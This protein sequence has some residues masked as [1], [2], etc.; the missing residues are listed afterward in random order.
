MRLQSR[1]VAPAILLVLLTLGLVVPRAEAQRGL[2]VNGYVEPAYGVRSADEGPITDRNVMQETRLMIEKKFYGDGGEALDL[3]VLATTNDATNQS[4]V[5]L[6][7]GSVFLPISRSIEMKIGRQVLSWGPSQFEFINDHFA[8]D[9][10]SFFV[11]RNLEFLKAPNDAVKFSYYGDWAN[12]DLVASPAFEPDRLPQGQ[13]IPLYHP[14]QRQ[15]V[16]ASNAPTVQTPDDSP[17]E[18]EYHL[19]LNQ[20]FGRWETALYGYRGFVGQPKGWNGSSTFYP[21]L[22]SAGFSLR[23]PLLDSIVWMEGSFNDIRND[24]AGDT[25]NLPTDRAQLG[26][27]LRYRT[28]R[29]VSYMVQAIS[30]WQMDAEQYRDLLPSDNPESDRVRHRLQVA[31]T[32]D[33]WSDRLTLELRGFVGLTEEDWHARAQTT[34]D[35]SDAITL[36]SGFL[37]YGREFATT[38]FGALEEHDMAFARLRYGF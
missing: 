38:R 9:Y 23:G 32:R 1:S 6:R 15:L 33:Y 16:N 29:T 36:S 21:E 8:K 5:E 24:L 2:N 10:R 18:G 20:T 3:K 34:Y 37:T 28:T 7:S 13:M 27:G 12:L 25:V 31:T 19:R 35:W 4:D 11:G 30:S 22:A 26:L 14:G 17:A